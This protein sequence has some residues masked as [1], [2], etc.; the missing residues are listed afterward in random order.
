MDANGVNGGPTKEL[1]SPTQT[2]HKHTVVNEP[3][4]I[5]ATSVIGEALTWKDLLRWGGVIIPIAVFA[6]WAGVQ[7]TGISS[8]QAL[9]QRD[10]N[11]VRSEVKAISTKIDEVA[12][13][14][15]KLDRRLWMLEGKK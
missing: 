3:S 4:Q 1:F 11:S 13:R 2:P 12:A 8:A 9:M 14:T 6:F 10:V 7:L 15:E 5:V